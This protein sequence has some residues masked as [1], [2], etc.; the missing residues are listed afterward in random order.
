[1]SYLSKESKLDEIAR[2]KRDFQKE[3]KHEQKKFE[4]SMNL[5]EDFLNEMK[6]KV[7]L[8]NNYQISELLK[9]DINK[10]FIKYI[11][12]SKLAEM[13]HL[14]INLQRKN[15]ILAIKYRNSLMETKKMVQF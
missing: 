3:L 10:K 13:E 1:M 11:K 7:I 4:E 8:K 2:E 6:K 9:S 12:K 5:N 14:I 15:E